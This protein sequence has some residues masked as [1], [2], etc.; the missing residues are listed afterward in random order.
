MEPAQIEAKDYKQNTPLHSAVS[1]RK[2][3]VV[4]FLIENGAQIESHDNI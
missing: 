3:E 4:K 1:N 2:H